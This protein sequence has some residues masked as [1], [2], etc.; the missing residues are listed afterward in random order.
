MRL[1]AI[2]IVLA[3][4]GCASTEYA[5]YAEA[6]K[7]RASADAARYAALAKIAEMGDTT[8]KVAAVISLNVQGNQQPQMAMP[9]SWADYALT[10]TGALLPVVGQ[11]Y[12]VNKQT[13]LGIRQSDNA[14][15]LGISQ[16][17]SNRDVQTA[18]VTGFSSMASLGFKAASDIST[19]GFKATSD[20]AANIKQPQ[21]NITISGTGIVGGGTLSTTTNTM[22]NSTGVLGTGS[23]MTDNRPST[24]TS[25]STSSSLTCTT[26]PC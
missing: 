16:A 13:S 6:Q 1:I 12:A 19:V 18:T 23:Y 10:F 15:L 3:L 26:G 5:A 14:T 11:M 22:S 4:T 21:P 8:A 25:T 20:I 9:R 17:N 2:P 24:S 7:A